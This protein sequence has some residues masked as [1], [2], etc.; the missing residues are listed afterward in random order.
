MASRGVIITITSGALVLF[1]L[2]MTAFAFVD[3]FVSGG[4]LDE[5]TFVWIL[6][7]GV[8]CT[9]I[10]GMMA[11]QGTIEENAKKWEDHQK[12][13]ALQE[14]HEYIIEV[15]DDVIQKGLEESDYATKN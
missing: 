6:A 14:E 13:L 11:P 1:G 5:F 2:L 10:G 15:M 7:T 3:F 8:A 9:A 12:Y 4:Q